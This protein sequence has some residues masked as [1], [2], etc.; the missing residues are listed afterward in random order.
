MVHLARRRAGHCRLVFQR[1][2]GIGGN[3]LRHLA[4]SER[5]GAVKVIG[6]QLRYHLPPN[7]AEFAVGQDAFQAIAHFNPALVVVDGQKN[8]HAAIR[9]LAAHLPLVFERV[10]KLRRVHAV[11]GMDGDH[12][13][14]RIGLGVVELAANAIQPGDRLRRKHVGKIA[15][16]I[17]GFG[18]VL[19]P[20]G[21]SGRGGNPH[22]SGQQ[23]PEDG[24]MCAA[25]AFHR[26]PLYADGRPKVPLAWAFWRVPHLGAGVPYGSGRRVFV[27]AARVGYSHLQS[28]MA[29]S[30]PSVAGHTN[31]RF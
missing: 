5:Y 9:A 10:G 25:K 8:Q 13:Y 4:H 29:S 17:G 27:F 20:L 26:S 30:S 1:D 12:G 24:R 11:Q 2:L 16:V 23:Q 14:L 15:H 19:H 31:S 22:E 6:P 18:Q 28:F 21:K 3:H 7:V